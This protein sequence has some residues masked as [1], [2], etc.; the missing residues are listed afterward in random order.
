[1]LTSSKDA[2][3]LA[4][5]VGVLCRDLSLAGGVG[6]RE[7]QRLLHMLAHLLNHFLQL[8]HHSSFLQ[9][10]QCSLNNT[11]SPRGSPA[12]GHAFCSVDVACV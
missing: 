2:L 6:Q 10:K 1:M 5:L 4:V 9:S 7:H 8:P 3:A 11:M 12:Q